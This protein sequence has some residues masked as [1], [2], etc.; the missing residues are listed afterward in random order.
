MN[1]I[2]ELRE[3]C[4]EMMATSPLRYAYIPASSIITLIERIE[5]AEAELSAANERLTKPVVLPAA[6]YVRIGYGSTSKRTLY[7]DEVI[8]VIK[9]AGF[10]VEGEC[11]C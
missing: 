5:K 4:E 3:H 8:T 6:T 9:A 7:L 1:N 2:E 11:R 10:T